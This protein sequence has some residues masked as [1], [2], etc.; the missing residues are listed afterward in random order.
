MLRKNMKIPDMMVLLK[1]C[2]QRQ[3][4]EMGRCVLSELKMRQSTSLP[5]VFHFKPEPLGHM[6]TIVY[7]KRG[8]C[9][10]FGEFPL[11]LHDRIFI[12]GRT[13]VASSVCLVGFFFF[14][15]VCSREISGVNFLII[16]LEIIQTLKHTALL[17]PI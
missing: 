11:S 1:G 6:C 3:I 4:H 7:N 15:R 13:F 10:N 2:V 8:T 12:S 9:A 16:S 17:N 5:E 14:E